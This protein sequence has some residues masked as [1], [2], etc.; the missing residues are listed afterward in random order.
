LQFPKHFPL[1]QLRRG[2]HK[3]RSVIEEQEALDVEALP[4]YRA[5]VD[6]IGFFFGIAGDEA[7]N[8]HAAMKIHAIHDFLHD[9][10]ADI[11]KI[12]VDAVGSGGGELFLPVRILV[13]DG[14]VE[15]EILGDPGAF[16]VGAGDANDAAAVN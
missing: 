9:F 16:V 4:D 15:T 6:Q 3:A 14:G 11:F 8:H 7:T 5:E 12:N 13:I 2:F 1:T 10:S